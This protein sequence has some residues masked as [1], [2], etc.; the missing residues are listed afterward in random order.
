MSLF[1][2]TGNAY[3]KEVLTY[4]TIHGMVN[5]YKRDVADGVEAPLC[6]SKVD[7]IPSTCGVE[8]HGAFSWLVENGYFLV[9]DGYCAITQKMLAR[10]IGH[11]SDIAP[12][13]AIIL[14][15]C[16]SAPVTARM[17]QG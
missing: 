11:F 3:E 14:P 8:N 13:T 9:S 1:R 6:A 15:G 4:Q 12:A 7:L 5:K 16:G 2:G 17:S 10:L